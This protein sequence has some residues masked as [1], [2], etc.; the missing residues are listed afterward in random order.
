[1]NIQHVPTPSGET[2]YHMFTANFFCEET[3]Y[4]MAAAE[5]RDD[6]RDHNEAY[7]IL[8]LSE[9]GTHSSRVYKQASRWESDSVLY[10]NEQVRIIGLLIEDAQNVQRLVFDHQAQ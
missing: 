7:D 4:K 9:R 3:F 6:S 2:N 5:S 10:S 1:M 8:L